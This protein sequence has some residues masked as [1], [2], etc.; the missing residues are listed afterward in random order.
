MYVYIYVYVY[1]Y[2]IM[3]QPILKYLSSFL[4]SDD[5]KVKWAL[6][7]IL[8]VNVRLTNKPIYWGLSQAILRILRIT[9]LE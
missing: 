7:K 6:V 9:S 3:I 8:L 5:E 1:I 4:G 2:N